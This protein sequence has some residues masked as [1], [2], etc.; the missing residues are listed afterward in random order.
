M[1]SHDP[2]FEIPWRIVFF[3]SNSIWYCL[4]FLATYHSPNKRHQ[5]LNLVLQNFGTLFQ[6]AYDSA[7]RRG[8]KSTVRT[9]G[10]C[11]KLQIRIHLV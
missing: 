4:H 3:S 8:G 9:H 11:A 1:A 7:P 10:L 6:A 2:Q 5:E